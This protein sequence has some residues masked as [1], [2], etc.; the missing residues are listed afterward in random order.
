MKTTTEI[1]IPTR[2]DG[3]DHDLLNATVELRKQLATSGE[4]NN[5]SNERSSAATN[6]TYFTA[7]CNQAKTNGVIIFSIAFNVTSSTTR[8]QMEACASST[9]YFYNVPNNDDGSAINGAFSSIALTI[10]QLR[11]TQ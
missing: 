1:Q 8:D 9:S 3:T 2:I 6:V 4:N 5:A 11:L 10:K 7:Q